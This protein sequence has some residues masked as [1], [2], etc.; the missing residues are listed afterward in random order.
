M[1]AYKCETC[2]EKFKVAS[3]LARHK[4]E[5]H[6]PPRT[7]KCTN[8]C[9]YESKRRYDVKRHIESRKCVLD[10][11]SIEPDES[12]AET[13]NPQPSTSEAAPLTSTKIIE[14]ETEEAQ[15]VTITESLNPD[16]VIQRIWLNETHSE[17][18]TQP[19]PQPQPQPEEPVIPTTSNTFQMSNSEDNQGPT[20]H[21]VT[22]MHQDNIRGN[23]TIENNQYSTSLMI[24]TDN[25][26][27]C[28]QM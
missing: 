2:N 20:L 25:P 9:G 3:T 15:V 18:L 22:I 7:F 21:A 14:Q 11:S 16:N 4:K 27:T 24:R 10:T 1:G 6:G 19:P 8:N 13:N 28:M 26:T 12:Q 5:Q 23:F 17:N